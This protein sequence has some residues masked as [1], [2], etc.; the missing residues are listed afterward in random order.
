MRP[1]PIGSFE[2]AMT[3]GMVDVA[4]FAAS[5]AAPVVRMTSTLRRTNSATISAARSLL[6]SAQAY[7]RRRRRELIALLSASSVSALRMLRAS[8][9]ISTQD[10]SS[11]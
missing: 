6:A 5:R 3:T 2:V 4:R 8:R 7:F 9:R 11:T 1:L 10:N